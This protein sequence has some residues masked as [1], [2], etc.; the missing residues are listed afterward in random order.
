MASTLFPP[1]IVSISDPSG[2][3]LTRATVEP[4][5]P[6]RIEAMGS[7]EYNQE[8]IFARMM[9]SRAVGVVPNTL[10]DLLMS[11][12]TPIGKGE[13]HRKTIGRTS[14]IAP[15]KYRDRERNQSSSYFRVT[16]GAQNPNANGAAGDNS[17]HSSAWDLT[18]DVGGAQ[19]ASP[20]PN[21][22][23]YFLPGN[24]LNI[25][26]ETGGNVAIT[27]PVKIVSVVDTSGTVATVTVE[28]PYTDAGFT[29]LSAPDK[30]KFNPTFG[31]ASLLTNNISDYESYCL[32]QPWNNT[33]E[34]LV[35]WFQ[36]SRFARAT[37][38]EY[39]EQL[40]RILNGEVNGFTK[41]FEYIDVVKR[42]Q[43]MRTEYDKQ[44]MNAVW[45]AGRINEYQVDDLSAVN[46]TNL[47]QVVDPEDAGCVYE[48]KAN[49]IGI[50]TQLK[51]NS[52]VVDMQGAALDM[53]L[54]LDLCYTMKR[55]RQLDGAPHDVIDF[56]TDRY[57][58]DNL[59]Q[60]LIK[61]LKDRYGYT[62]ERHVTNGQI[63]VEGTKIIQ[64]EYTVYDIPRYHFR[65]ALFT[66]PFFDDRLDAFSDAGTAGAD[67]SSRGRLLVGLDWNDIQIG[68]VETNTVHRE[69]KNDI[70]AQANP[71]FSC[72]M[73]LNTKMYDLESTTW[74]V[75]FGD[76]QRHV[77]VENYSGACPTITNTLCT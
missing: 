72:V 1:R 42:N 45:F 46:F 10:S 31:V 57:T 22:A 21:P 12:I 38:K 25:E 44:F 28:A 9:E 13:L 66:H 40:A 14:I 69:Y 20:L 75:E 11:R 71:A 60:V 15:F 3:S 76:F 55:H 61:Y 67:I 5:T 26:H 54:L 74:D 2:C 64:W 36:T 49:A 68:V 63:V 53:D 52:R 37:N 43:Q 18:I 34:L 41:K 35:D 47:E 56:M 33:Q 27:A 30:A 58:K 7:I 73:R 29:A 65:I 24:Y 70:T 6:D 39:E 77:M 17:L 19:F 16:A 4:L 23:R 62:I 32:N 8:A 48:Y 50:Y 51:E 59:D